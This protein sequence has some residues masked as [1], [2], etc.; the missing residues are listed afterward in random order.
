M[1]LLVIVTAAL[2]TWGY[3]WLTGQPL[4]QRGYSAVVVLPDVEGLTEGDQVQLSGVT[5]G[6]V[7]DVKLLSPGR[8]AVTL[9]LQRGVLIP[10]DSRAVLQSVGVLGDKVIELRAGSSEVTLDEGDTLGVG[11]ASSL[12]TLA[13]DLGKEAESVLV[14]LDKLL[15]DT[16]IEHA[17]GSLAALEGALREMERLIH[18]NSGEL[19]A[20]SESLRGTARSL[21]TAVGGGTLDSTLVRI[22]ATASRLSRAAET[23]ERSAES[24]SSV[25][26]KIDSGEGTLGRLVNDPSLYEDLRAA[27]HNTASLVQD[28]QQNPGR[29]LK[30]AIF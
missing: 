10:R 28:M 22:E 7:S 16:A 6:H 3:F 21:E 26:A 5:V 18:A 8:V 24:V 15:A 23:L 4:G 11:S 19:T 30:F 25:V 13:G 9:F 17:H 27:A 12:F 2:L 20:M 29:Y 14:Q 1:G